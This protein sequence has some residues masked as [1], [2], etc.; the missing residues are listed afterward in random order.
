[1]PTDY[2]CKCRCCSTK[3]T[4]QINEEA[5]KMAGLFRQSAHIH[6]EDG[7]RLTLTSKDIDMYEEGAY[8]V[9]EN[10]ST[11][12]VL[13]MIPTNRISSATVDRGGN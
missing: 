2:G 10:R 12:E 7:E 4:Y 5:L 9:I 1:M 3:I 13:G 6:M 11:R 8:L